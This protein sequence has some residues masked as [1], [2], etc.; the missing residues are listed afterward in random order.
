M[1]FVSMAPSSRAN[2]KYEIVFMKE[3]GRPLT[4]HFGSKNSKTY[5]DHKDKTKR[6]NYISRHAPNEQWQ[7]VNPGSLSRF[8]LWGDATDLETNLKAYFKRFNIKN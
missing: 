3:N 1:N 4:I 5:L 2:K 8:L 7:E 6:A